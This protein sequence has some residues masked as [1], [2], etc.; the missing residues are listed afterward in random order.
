MAAAGADELSLPH[1]VITR[2][3]PTGV[4]TYS[5]PYPSALEAMAAADAERCRSTQDPGWEVTFDIAPLCEPADDGH[6]PDCDPGRPCAAQDAPAPRVVT[7][8]DGGGS[9][10]HARP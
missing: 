2:D 9:A 7:A 10:R 3:V 4:L 8:E 1:I 6:R 5:G